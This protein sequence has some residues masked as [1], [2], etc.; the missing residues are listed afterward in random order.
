[1][2]DEAY[3]AGCRQLQFIGGEP[4]LHPS[5][6][7]FIRHAAE[8]GYE[9]IEVFTNTNSMMSAGNVGKAVYA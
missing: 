9:F 7:S 2:I 3:D 8:K 5:L 6:D 1:V 4:T